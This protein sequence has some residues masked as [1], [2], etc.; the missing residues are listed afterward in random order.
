MSS[1]KSITNQTQNSTTNIS[2][3]NLSSSSVKGYHSA[4]FLSSQF[5][6][7]S[8]EEAY[9]PINDSFIINQSENKNNV[10]DGKANIVNERSNSNKLKSHDLFKL[11]E[12]SKSLLT[13]FNDLIKQNKEEKIKEKRR[14]LKEE[15]IIN[16]NNF[17]KEY[18]NII[19]NRISSNCYY[20]KKINENNKKKTFTLRE[21]DWI[22][23]KCN[24][25][26]FSFRIICNKCYSMK[27]N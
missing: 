16:L 7:K 6:I 12:N 17:L 25:L 24:N 21:G 22:C 15:S 3:T 1:S 4:L 9:I 23:L 18:N 26:N 10:N 2:S 11:N 27:S 19:T 5:E 13:Q 8:N 14:S 20:D